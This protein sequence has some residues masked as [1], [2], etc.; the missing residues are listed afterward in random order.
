MTKFHPDRHVS[1]TD[2]DKAH[3]ASIATDVTRAYSIV[4]EP[5]SRA[6]HLLELYG[7][8]IVESDNV[9]DVYYDVYML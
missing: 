9:S 1:S 3:N 7:S 6:L 4:G 5:L 2:E 8:P